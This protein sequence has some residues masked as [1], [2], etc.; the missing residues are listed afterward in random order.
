MGWSIVVVPSD[1]HSVPIDYPVGWN[2]QSWVMGMD[3]GGGH[4]S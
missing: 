2:F 1:E 4:H 3:H